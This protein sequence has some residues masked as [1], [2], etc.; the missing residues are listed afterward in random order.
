MSGRELA[1][2]V[3]VPDSASMEP[4]AAVAAHVGEVGLFAVLQAGD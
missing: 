4:V 1:M 3:A 2:S